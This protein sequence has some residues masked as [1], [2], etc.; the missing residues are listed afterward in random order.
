M[1]TI[2]IIVIGLLLS[3]N[4]FAQEI[5]T[6]EFKDV[7]LEQVAQNDGNTIPNQIIELTPLSSW[8]FYL[9]LLILGFAV[10]VLIILVILAIKGILKEDNIVKYVTIT[11][12]ITATLFLVTAGY[13][14]Y[15]IAPAMGLLGTIA[16]YLLGKQEKSKKDRDE[17]NQ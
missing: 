9:S 7:L 14:Q 4:L 8:E 15:Q 11:L 1:K 12:I 10:I 6:S 17:M 16:G 13:N 5:D 3:P 2:R